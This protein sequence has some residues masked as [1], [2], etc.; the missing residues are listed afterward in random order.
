MALAAVLFV[1]LPQALGQR[2]PQVLIETNLGNIT[3]ELYPDEAPV[4]VDNFLTY[5]NGG[6]YDG[7]LFH[8]VI[9][10]FMIQGGWLFYQDGQFK[11]YYTNPP[12]INESD[13]GLSNLKGTLAMARTAAPDSATAQFFINHADNLFLDR[14]NAADGFGYCVF[15]TVVSGMDVVDIIA[16]VPVIPTGFS[17]AFPDAP[18]VEMED[19]SVLPCDSVQC[20][21]FNGDGTVNFADLALLSSYWLDD[22]GCGSANDFCSGTDL[23]YSGQ[24]NA[25]DLNMFANNWLETVTAD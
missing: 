17:E 8:R 19:V 2:N 3:V 24:L 23:N 18:K 22:A 4:T 15:A 10:D 25:V 13:N 16:N 20:S 7:L 11:Y 9:K 1:L 5:A 12:I 14:A 6:F 21:D